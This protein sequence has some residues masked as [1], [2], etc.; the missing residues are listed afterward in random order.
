MK[1]I[2]AFIALFLSMIFVAN[3]QQQHALLIGIDH[4]APPANYVPSSDVGRLDF[5]NLDGCI[6]DVESMYSIISSSLSLKLLT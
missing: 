4:Y 5:P 2:L 3:A 1:K 6:N